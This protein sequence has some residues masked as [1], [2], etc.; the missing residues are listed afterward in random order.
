MKSKQN[1]VVVIA[2]FFLTALLIAYF[3]PR[4][5]QFRYQ[6]NEGKPWRYGLLTAPQDFPI[7]KTDEEVKAEKDSV[8]K[9]F[10]PYYRIDMDAWNRQKSKL[11]ESY[12]QNA[13]NNIAYTRYI[14][15]SL[16]EL[17]KKGIVSSTELEKL[18]GV[19]QINLVQSNI[20]RLYY[21]SD[22]FTVKSAYEFVINNAPRTI[23]KTVLRTYNI[24]NF[25]IENVSYDTTMTKQM[26]DE[27]LKQIS[28]A[29]GLIQAGERIVDRGEIIDNHTY[30][31]LRS[32]KIV[33]ETRS[34]GRE[35]QYLILGGLTIFVIST[36]ACF[37]LYLWTFMPKLLEERKTVVF[38]LL[39]ILV[40]SILTELCITHS[41]FNVYIIP[42]AIVPIVVRV[43][44]NSRTALF[45]HLAVSIICA[46]MA[47]FPFEFLVLQIMTGMVVLFSLKDLSERSHLIR[48]AFFVFITY[49]LCYLSITVYLEADLTKI[50]WS[51]LLYFGINFILLMFTYIFVYFLEKSFGYISS[52][53]LIELSNINTALL[54]RL[55]ETCPGTF[56][57]SLQVS[58]LASEAAMKINAN[59][60]LVRTGAMYHDIGKMANPAFFTENQNS[61]NPHTQLSLE[62]SA[63]IIISHVPEGVKIAEKASIP[64]TIID[65]IRTHHGKGLT[66][67]FYNSYKN[68]YPDREIDEA[69][70]M[71]PGPNPFTKEQAVL[72]MADAVEAAS[73]SLK[74]H[75]EEEISALVNRIID[76]QL[77][78]GVL[79]SAPLTFRDVESVKEVFIEKLKTIY[80]TRISYP[81]LKK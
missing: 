78:E 71:Y 6:F 3:F 69:L 56:Q 65:F 26:Q 59:A 19:Q 21:V 53:T 61:V 60:Q 12:A 36:I 70:F 11:Q 5:G 75:T 2:L 63:Q 57:H 41:L 73:R 64:E 16:T 28:I 22:L 68:K 33:H 35:R 72:M 20:A 23:D 66:G 25:L 9:Y 77:E 14:E 50:N 8:L 15:S 32:L 44:F 17:Y 30:N 74:E 10:S 49:T 18:N 40:P 24:D 80:H 67:Y 42:Y 76:R 58:I 13:N 7:Y 79:K 39:C 51:M 46:L 31:V 27:M 43:F 55:S 48:C 54:K 47:P 34:G 1:I 45:T 38:L 29:N 4:E 52:V 37:W 62:E 81:E